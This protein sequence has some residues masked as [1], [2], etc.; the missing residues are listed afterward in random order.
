MHLQRA[1][2]SYLARVTTQF[3]ADDP[4]SQ[5]GF[6][7]LHAQGFNPPGPDTPVTLQVLA[8][9][10]IGNGA[11]RIQCPWCPGSNQFA[12]PETQT[13]FVCTYCANAEVGFNWVGIE[14][15]VDRD[16]IEEALIARQNPTRMNWWP[17]EA[18]EHL[19]AE[20]IENGVLP[21]A[22]IPKHRQRL[23]K[24]LIEMGQEVNPAH[25]IAKG[26]IVHPDSD[27]FPKHHAEV[28]KTLGKNVS[29]SDLIRAV[30]IHATGRK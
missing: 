10:F 26:T 15:P 28:A 12:N 23:V 19:H 29:E 25:V 2:A 18:P 8:Q 16:E 30:F 21:L 7:R 13:K 5:Q 1:D 3:H 11:W 6:W 24:F 27:W 4:P 20:N 14:W 22:A 17:H 9:A